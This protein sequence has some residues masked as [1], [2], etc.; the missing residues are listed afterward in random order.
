MDT[1]K[2][3]VMEM[4]DEDEKRI[5]ERSAKATISRLKYLSGMISKYAH[6][7]GEDPSSRLTGWVWEYNDIKDGRP[8]EW[9]AYCEANGFA[10]DHDGYDVLA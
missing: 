2:E 4:V 3:R 1:S 10:E 8:E 5:A 9:K 7:W 6:R